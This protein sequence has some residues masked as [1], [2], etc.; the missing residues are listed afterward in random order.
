MLTKLF[1]IASAN[2]PR[3]AK[4]NYFQ[5]ILEIPI[6][7]KGQWRVINEVLSKGRTDRS[8][9]KLKIHDEVIVNQQEIFNSFNDYFINI[10]PKLA[11]NIHIDGV[12][13]V[14][15][16]ASQESPCSVYLSTITS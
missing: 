5:S 14:P 11:H 6:D 4:R 16:T 10:G 8:I 9:R 2:Q 1:E 12:D 3:N 15:M 7:V 13:L